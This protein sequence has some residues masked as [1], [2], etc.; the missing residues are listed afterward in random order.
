MAR[1]AAGPII[2]ILVI[3]ACTAGPAPSPS[4]E[5][6]PCEAELP[7]RTSPTDY[8][9]AI[10]HVNG[11]DLPPV[12]GEVDWRGGAEPLA[13][14]APRPVHVQRFTVLQVRQAAE[15]AIRMS[16]GVSIAEWR[17]T[18]QPDTAFRAGDTEPV[19]EWTSGSDPGDV[20]CVPL[21]A[22]SWAIRADLTFADAAGSGTYYWRL[23]VGEA[24]SG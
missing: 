19:T 4:V 6:R 22:G 24:P 2:A 3:T 1:R 10:L 7:P 16:D 23:N 9:L 20:V 18:A 15:A 14:S 21:E 17:V 11:D 5:A 13:T 8:P 12:V